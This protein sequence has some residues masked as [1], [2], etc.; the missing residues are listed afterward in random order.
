[1]LSFATQIMVRVDD[2]YAIKTTV[3]KAEGSTAK[4]I[5]N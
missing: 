5:E 3:H 2:Q 1:V 4:T